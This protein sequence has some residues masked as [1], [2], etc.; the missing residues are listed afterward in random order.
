MMDSEAWEGADFP[1]RRSP[2][3]YPPCEC[4]EAGCP[5]RLIQSGSDKVRE[6]CRP[7]EPD[8][9]VLQSLRARVRDENDRRRFGRL[10]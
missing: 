3:I 2:L 1:A 6:T 10:G 8:S 7:V 9:P 5:D 4:G